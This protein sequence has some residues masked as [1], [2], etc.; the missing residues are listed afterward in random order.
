MEYSELDIRNRICLQQ[1]A[2]HRVT[3]R[4]GIELRNP[5]ILRYADLIQEWGRP[6]WGLIRPS[7]RPSCRYREAEMGFAQSE[8]LYMYGNTMHEHRESPRFPS[9]VEPGTHREA[10]GRLR[11]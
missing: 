2:K 11:R 6:R 9:A 8:T 7:P 1:Q 5:S 3:C 10:Y 4:S